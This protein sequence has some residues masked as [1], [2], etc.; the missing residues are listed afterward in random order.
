MIRGV[1]PFALLFIGTFGSCGNF[2]TFTSKRLRNN[3]CTFYF[4]WT[5]IFELLTICFGLIS[6]IAHQFGSKLQ[7]ESKI[8]CK[9]RYYFALTFP[10]VAT[11][12]LLMAAYRS[13]HVNIYQYSMSCIQSTQYR[14][15]YGIICHYTMF[16]SMF[17]CSYLCQSSTIMYTST[18]S[19]FT[20][21]QCV[22]D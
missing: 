2:I 14:L 17:T 13:M 16:H 7:N 20:I 18:G 1:F 10:S 19:I 12:L 21:L 9:I 4:L 15:S 8:Y 22:F 6:R 3:S 11:Y 5:A